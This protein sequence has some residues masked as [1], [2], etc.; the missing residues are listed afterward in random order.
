MAPTDREFAEFNGL[1]RSVVE[2]GLAL[3]PAVELMAGVVRSPRLRETL[4]SVAADLKDGAPL[5][6]A[7]ARHPVTFSPEYCALVRAGLAGGRLPEVLRAA[8]VHAAH[9][10]RVRSKFLRLLFYLAAGAMVGEIALL[11][12]QWAGSHMGK[13]HEQLGLQPRTDDPLQRLI[14]SGWTL[15]IAWP[16]S[17]ALMLGG[18]FVLERW[19][20]FSWIGYFVP[21]WSQIQKS[22]D[23]SLFCSTLGLR[24]RSGST[25]LDALRSAQACVAS[26]AFRRC[27]RAV[28]R[29]VEEGE[30]LSSALFYVRYFP[31]TLGWGLSIAEENG[32]IPRTLDTFAG[33]YSSQMERNFDLLYELL[34]PL[35]ILAVGNVTLLSAMMFMLPILRVQEALSGM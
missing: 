22:R 35:G 30:A 10:A 8:E 19:A 24:L 3:A 17:V 32:E 13:I 9:R 14:G 34:T 18:Y 26:G 23:L 28:V 15:L 25:M 20:R 21:L 1:L 33:L 2:K 11:L 29:R 4:K 6:D 7:L 27:A 31:K 16:A 5:P 12:C